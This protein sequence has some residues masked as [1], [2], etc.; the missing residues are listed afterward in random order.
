[1]Q[2][3]DL[4]CELLLAGSELPNVMRHLLLT[5]A[6]LVDALPHCVDVERHFV[7]QLVIRGG[8]GW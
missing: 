5:G 6:E 7:D 3:G 4:E 1:V 8:N 2:F